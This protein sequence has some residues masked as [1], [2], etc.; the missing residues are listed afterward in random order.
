MHKVIVIGIDG[1]SWKFIQPWIDSGELPNIKKLIESGVSG[2]MQSEFPFVTFPAWKCYSTGKNPAKLGVFGWCNT[3]LKERIIKI[4]RPDSIKSR[5]LWDYLCK[6]GYRVGIIDVPT[7]YPPKEVDGFFISGSVQSEDWEFTYPKELKQEIMNKYNY[8]PT[9][10][11]GLENETNELLETYKGFLRSR[12]NLAYDKLGE[13]DFMQ[14]VYGWTDPMQHFLWGTKTPKIIWKML[15]TQIGRFDSSKYNIIIMSDHG[16]VEIDSMFYINRW[17]AEHGYLKLSDK[18]GETL[19]KV[20]ITKKSLSDFFSKLGLLGLVKK[21]VSKKIRSRIRTHHD[22]AVG[23]I[24]R[25][26]LIDWDRTKITGDSE[27]PIYINVNEKTEEYNKIVKKLSA[28]LLEVRH[29]GTNKRVI[30]K[31]FKRDEIYSGEYID[32]APHL[33]LLQEEGFEI[34][35]AMGSPYVFRDDSHWVA[36]HHPEAIFI[37]AGPDIKNDNTKI[38][39]RVIDLMP[40]V[41][42][43]M[44][45][46][47]PDDV[48]GK[49]LKKVF[50]SDSNAAKREVI[51]VKV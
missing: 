11:L 26:A 32:I 30:K 16:F 35:G 36:S 37:A 39:G 40:T 10:K 33:F 5:E 42:H 31:I 38:N 46:P 2:I 20:G 13:V 24:D 44:G 7:T 1:A 45:L 9:T 3:Y 21:V 17:L 49:V 4:N 22:G 43:L 8:K 29:P 25:N 14:V 18:M 6:G 23:S 12:F 19:Y 28:E 34:N 48:D 51:F 15:D 50:K 47:I 27:G 41:L